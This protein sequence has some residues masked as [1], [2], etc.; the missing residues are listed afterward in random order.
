MRPPP[1]ALLASASP[2]PGPLDREHF[3]AFARWG[4]RVDETLRLEFVDGRIVRRP[5]PDGTHGRMLQWLTLRCLRHDAR[6]W[7]HADRGVGLTTRPS[8]CARPDGVLA[9]VDASSGTARGR[10][11]T[12]C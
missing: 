7:L 10:P 4:C 3:E 2:A 12:A 1:L 6:W 9:P 5:Q 8:G 11:P